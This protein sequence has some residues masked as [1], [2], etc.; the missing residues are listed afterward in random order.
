MT[1]GGTPGRELSRL[2]QGFRRTAGL[3]QQDLAARAGLSAAAIRDLEQC[4]TRRPRPDSISALAAALALGPAD[5][6]A[7]GAAALRVAAP[8]AP[9]SGSRP[10]IGALGPLV[11][12]RGDVELDAGGPGPRTLLGRLALSPGVPVARAE[13]I[14]LLWPAEVPDSAI[15]LIQTYV[16]RLRRVLEPDRPP[17]AGSGVVNLAPGGY[18]LAAGKQLDVVRFQELVAAARE[19]AAERPAEAGELLD[20]ALACWRGDP[21]SD[22]DGL[23]DHPAAVALG[24]ERIAAA[25]LRADVAHDDGRHE[26]ALRVLRP[27]ADRH[28]LHEAIAGRLMLALAATGRQA[29]ALDAYDD[30]R[31]RLIEQLGIDPG[32]GLAGCRQRVLRRE[33]GGAAAAAPVDRAPTPFQVPAAPGDFTG[34]SAELRLL[35]RD[36]R[37]D[38]SAAAVVVHAISGVAGVGKTALIRTVAGRLREDFPDGQ[39][40]IDLL[41]AGDRPLPPVEALGRLL[42]ALGLDPDPRDDEAELAALYRSVLAGRRMLVVLDN[43]RDAAQVRPLLPGPGRCATLVTSR[44]RLPHLEGARLLDLDLLPA[45]DAVALLAAVAGPARTSGDPQAAADLVAACGRL[46]LAIRIAG[47]RLAGR[48]DWDL[49]AFLARLGDQRRRLDE[50]TVGDLD[51]RATFQLSYAH[52]AP[53]LARA[54]RLLALAPGVDIGLPAAATVLAAGP[55]EAE[56]L[57]GDL[58]D[59]SLLERAGQERYRFHDLIRL[60]AYQQ[61]TAEEA[62]PV[63]SAA[64]R[65]LLEWYH[66]RVAA[67]VRVLSPTVV[68]L[69]PRR[70]VPEEPVTAADALAWLGQEMP[71]LVAAIEQ[72]AEDGPGD[73]AWALADLLRGYFFN[74]RAAPQWLATAEAGLAA[75]V[76]AGNRLAEAA[77]HQTL[78][79]ALWSV[80]DLRRSRT[81]YQLGLE[82]AE[83][84]GWTPGVGYQL[85]NLGLVEV[86]LGDTGAA[87]EHYLRSL[88][89]CTRGGLDQ[90]RA[91]TLNDLGMMCWEQGAFG[92]AVDYLEQ[93]L[94]VN[95]RLGNGNGEATNRTNLGIVLR[96]QGRFDEA[97]EHIDEAS[98]R[99]RASG[100]RYGELAALDELSQLHIWTG[101]AGTAPALARRALDLAR[102]VQDRTYQAGA[103]ASLGEA[104][105]AAGDAVGAVRHLRIAYETA[106]EIG[107]AHLS[108]RA[109]AGLAAAEAEQGSAAVALRD[110]ASA[111]AAARTAGYRMLEV[112]ALLAVAA[113]RMAGGEL[114][115]AA[116]ACD[117]AAGLA[118]AIGSPPRAAR[119]AAL[120]AAA[121]RPLAAAES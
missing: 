56:R 74:Q 85:H 100:S 72:A 29:D 62:E 91:V 49:R 114:A 17:R 6:A 44:R 51:V 8:A 96:D 46:P 110:A 95:G 21:V 97:R 50:L 94:E 69:P 70:P 79:Q 84:T 80:G 117:E 22:L 40:H 54:F 42:R 33:W 115:G 75:A 5:A 15:N 119:A 43:A 109:L 116:Q 102:A 118:T 83:Q 26:E 112:D 66:D 52:L 48:A 3:T 31:R 111:L 59:A 41:G 108:T 87:R 58:V 27:L 24:E 7:L 105:L 121:T 106:R 4:R 55:A 98:A 89:V 47:A 107:A 76:A 60:Y 30:I 101:P 68:R 23:R 2:L 61:A 64:V 77:M 16:S 63:R 88:D 57:L 93:A 39:L 120:L 65:R 71:N 45:G 34:R 53:P 78:A 113:A 36:L 13:L 1:D 28:P 25:L 18:R 99:W 37:A 86:A 104:L 67:G 32:P 73:F 92:E 35:V 103:S 11:V 90:V 20:R 14:D 10:E 38:R 19:A 82:R 12:R 9:R 81:Q